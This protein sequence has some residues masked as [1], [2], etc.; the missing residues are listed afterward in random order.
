MARVS[1]FLITVALIVAMV[2]C[3]EVTTRYSLTM[4]VAPGG[5]GTATDL[6]NASPYAAG[7]AVSIKAV[8][9]VGYQFVKWTAPAGTFANANAAET[10]F[11]MPAQAVTVTA[12][13]FQG[14]LIRDWNDL[15]A[16]RDNLGDNYLLMNNLDSTTAGY[17]ERAKSTANGGQGWQ[18]IGTLVAAFTGTFDGQGYEIKDLFINRPGENGVGLFG[19]VEGGGGIENVEMVDADVIGDHLVG[20]LVGATTVVGTGTVSNSSATGSVSGNQDVGGLVGQNGGGCTVSNSYA[21]DNVTGVSGS[22]YSA[23]VGGLVGY[24]GG[25]VSNSY[26]TGSVT[27]DSCVGGLVGRNDGGTVSNSYA[28]GSVTGYG[29]VG[30]LVGLNAGGTVS[31]SYATGNVTVTG[32]AYGVGGLMGSNYGTVS[33]SYA[34][35]SVTASGSN[36]VGGL[37][38]ENKGN[39]SNSYATGSVTGNITVGG[40]A[41]YNEGTVDRSYSTGSVTGAGA[42]GGLVGVN[43]GTVSNS[44]WDTQTSGQGTSAGGTGKTTVQM[45]SIA[46]FSGVGWNII[47]VDNSNERNTGYVWNIVDGGTYPFLSWKPV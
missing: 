13:F 12:N 44:F 46:T 41:G 19:V 31:N 29:Y 18:P 2:G 36:F 4:A 16:I 24:N 14:Q 27:G 35:G 9:A 5:S 42:V 32:Y 20:I 21:I 47:A 11:T 15:N 23:D 45:K 28:T 26:A 43:Y 7:T 3:S 6:T 39:V 1:V 25:T 37:M 17:T 40:L 10:T 33:N 22:E 8:A 38:G 34:T 30:C